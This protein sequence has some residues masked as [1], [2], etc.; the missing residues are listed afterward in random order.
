MITTVE[1]PNAIQT[2]LNAGVNDLL[3]TPF[4]VEELLLK[5]DMHVFC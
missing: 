2:A 1:Q 4:T 3:A 5:I